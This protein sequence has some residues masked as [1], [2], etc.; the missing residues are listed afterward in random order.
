MSSGPLLWPAA[1]VANCSGWPRRYAADTSYIAATLCRHLHVRA[2]CSL[3][4]TS[5]AS[6]PFC[7]PRRQAL[8]T[9]TLDWRHQ[10]PK[11]RKRRGSKTENTEL[12]PSLPRL[13]TLS[14]NASQR[15]LKCAIPP[16]TCKPCDPVSHLL[17]GWR[18][19]WKE[20]LNRS[21]NNH[22]M[23]VGKW[24]GLRESGVCRQES[25]KPSHYL[26]NFLLSLLSCF[27]SR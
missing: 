11:S 5:H 1:W 16:A 15:P 7:A 20:V 25:T 2:V 4:M 12:P 26:P 3:T 19:E 14:P 17:V 24:C 18:E 8:T 13:L 22:P 9:A 27:T 10:C 23:G 21:A 6:S